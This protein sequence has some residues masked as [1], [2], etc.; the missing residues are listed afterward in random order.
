VQYLQVCFRIRVGNA[1]VV[2]DPTLLFGESG[3]KMTIDQS[4]TVLSKHTQ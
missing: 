3:L 4:Y 1:F 2:V